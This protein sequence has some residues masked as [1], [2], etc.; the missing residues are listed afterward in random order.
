[1]VSEAT[2]STL[3]RHRCEKLGGRDRP[4][5]PADHLTG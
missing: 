4:A 2:L 3:L 1:L 5:R